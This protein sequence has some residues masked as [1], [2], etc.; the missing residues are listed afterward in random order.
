MPASSPPAQQRWVYGGKVED[1]IP[2]FL[3]DFF[4]VLEKKGPEN[5]GIFRLNGNVLDMK[6]LEKFLCFIFFFVKN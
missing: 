2:L 5:E 4:S 3:L 6:E 1:K